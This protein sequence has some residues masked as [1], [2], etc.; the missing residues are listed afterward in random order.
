MIDYCRVSC[1]RAAYIK[2]GQL[3]LTKI[4]FASR[5]M[6][7]KVRR[8][9]EWQREVVV[10]C[11]GGRPCPVPYPLPFPLPRSSPIPLGLHVSSPPSFCP[12]PLPLAF[13][14]SMP[15]CLLP[16]PSCSRP[17]S[18]ATCA[19]ALCS[20]SGNSLPC[21]HG[22]AY[23]KQDIKNFTCD[24]QPLCLGQRDRL[25][26]G[27]QHDDVVTVTTKHSLSSTQEENCMFP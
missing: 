1:T 16:P 3:P 12:S 14:A 21:Q 17:L 11:R 15:P 10:V 4:A 9:D 26:P 8:S 19:L 7:L 6:S 5:N 23:H 18:P 13:L 25:C 22:L 27:H 20:Y 2:N 24:N